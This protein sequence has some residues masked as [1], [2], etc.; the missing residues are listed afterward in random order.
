[1][2]EIITHPLALDGKDPRNLRGD[3]VTP[4]RYWSRD[5]MQREW[6]HL[7]TKI[8]HIA[9][10]TNQLAEPGDY[11]VHDFMHES[12]YIVVQ[13]DGSLKGFY[14]ACGHRAQKLVRGNGSQDSFTCPYHG[15]VWDLD[16]GLLDA[17]DR[18]DFPQGDPVGRVGL[19]PGAASSGT[20][21]TTRRPRS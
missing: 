12:V 19:T 18:D 20:P 14:N 1:M 15:W 4:D 5:W 17:C 16:G 13:R 9:G 3:P 7:W 2:N 10:R 6:E 21:W 8:W 11:I